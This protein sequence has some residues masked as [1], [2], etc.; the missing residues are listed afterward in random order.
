MAMHKAKINLD[1]PS[2]LNPKSIS[3]PFEQCDGVVAVGLHKGQ[4]L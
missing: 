3:D 1:Y 4:S 2:L